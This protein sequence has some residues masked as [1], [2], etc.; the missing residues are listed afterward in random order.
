MELNEQALKQKKFWQEEQIL[1]PVFDRAL[2]K[3]KSER[4]PVWLHFGPGN[5]F[6]AF[7]AKLQQQLLD[8]GE[9]KHGIIAVAPNSRTI[10][11]QVYAPFDNLSLLVTM[12]PDGT[13]QKEVIGSITEAV[14]LVPATADWQRLETVIAAPTLQILSFTITE[15]GYTV[16]DAQGNLLA[17]VAADAA[18]G[19]TMAQSFFGK[20]TA[21]LVHRFN[22]G[23]FPVTLLSLDNCSH[24][25][26][27]LQAA[28]ITMA[29]AWSEHGFVPAAFVDYA[30]N[31]IT[32]P[33]SMIDKITPRPAPEVQAALQ[34]EGLNDMKITTSARGGYYA[35]FVNAES[36]GYLVIEDHFS[37]GRPPLEKAGVI[38]TNRQTVEKVERMKVSTCLNP[39]HTT[40]AVYGCL[41]GYT[42][43]AAEMQDKELSKLVTC[44]G[45]EAMQVVEDPKVLSPRAFL[46]ECLT[47]RFPNKAIPDTPQRIA[48][49]TSKKMGPRFG[50][51]IKAFGPAASG[52]KFIPLALAGWCRY[53]LAIDDRG[54]PME[55]SPDPL[56]PQLT[57][58]LQGIKLGDT[59]VNVHLH[60]KDILSSERIFGSNLYATALG[61]KVEEYFA[62]MLQGPGAVRRT[63]QKYLS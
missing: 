19:P 62:E 50:G 28:V 16:K 4:E 36:T 11:D 26:D 17:P 3:E 33:W 57:K 15:K 10:I 25:G 53:L 20:L 32:Y 8:M 9:A 27:L 38:F 44:I 7:I 39:L 46:Q 14:A 51:T 5:I 61:T 22:A 43:I 45:E 6:R 56:L 2:V 23:A 49:D 30:R 40:L 21:L 35:P 24:N 48:C 54:K 63:L 41:F 29:Q 31:K 12:Y 47:K 55:L 13:M 59:T 52:L 1:L 58:A 18:L 60:L 34:A 37:N 42:L